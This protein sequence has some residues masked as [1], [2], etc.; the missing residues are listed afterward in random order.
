[1]E[2]QT[3]DG[4]DVNPRFTW[5]TTVANE[6]MQDPSKASHGTSESII[7]INHLTK[8]FQGKTKTV[9]AVDD[10]SFNVDR[11]EIFGLLGSNGAGKSTLS[12]SLRLSSG[13]LQDQRLSTSTK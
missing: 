7:R 1:M 11:G 10:I 12:G 3:Y 9:R 6:I 2:P 4:D 13:R 5:G 8:V